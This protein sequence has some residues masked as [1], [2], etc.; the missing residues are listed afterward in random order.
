MPMTSQQA[1][2]LLNKVNKLLEGRTP[3]EGAKR[4]ITFIPF[5]FKEDV[6]SKD[7]LNNSLRNAKAR[8]AEYLT[9][10]AFAKEVQK[11]AR[12]QGQPAVT[13]DNLLATFKRFNDEEKNDILN[14]VAAKKPVIVAYGQRLPG[15]FVIRS[16]DAVEIAGH[17]RDTMRQIQSS[18]NNIEAETVLSRLHATF[19][20]Q[21]KNI[22]KIKL[23]SCYSGKA[24]MDAFLDAARK[25]L[26]SSPPT[27]TFKATMALISSPG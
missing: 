10:R 22:Q 23:T 6:P 19:G 1:E 17:G 4:R 26:P 27:P 20:D 14:K 18:G 8:D 13:A 21:T 16:H 24:F 12:L 2:D 25:K 15:D 11:L 9:V 5:T 7:H 3:A